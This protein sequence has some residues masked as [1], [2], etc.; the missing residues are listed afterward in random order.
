MPPPNGPAPKVLDGS[1]CDA[2]TIVLVDL[3]S[4]VLGVD[5]SAEYAPTVTVNVSPGVT[6]K[7]LIQRRSP[8]LPIPPGATNTPDIRYMLAG[9]TK[10]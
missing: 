9:T 10:E 5:R 8:P 6:G 7:L 3:L 4:I 1:D 2:I